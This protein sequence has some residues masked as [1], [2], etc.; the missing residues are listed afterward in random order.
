LRKFLPLYLFPL[1]FSIFSYPSLFF[2]FIFKLYFSFFLPS[3]IIFIHPEEMGCE[4]NMLTIHPLRITT[5]INFL[6]ILYTTE[7]NSWQVSQK[8][9]SADIKA[10][11]GLLPKCKQ[12]K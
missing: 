4:I 2:Y 1:F 7:L 10:S 6:K 3:F 8:V 11:H 5:E 9:Q 12:I